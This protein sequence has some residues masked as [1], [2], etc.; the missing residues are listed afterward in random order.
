[1]GGAKFWVALPSK[2]VTSSSWLGGES[3]TAK[4]GSKVMALKIKRS[5]GAITRNRATQIKSHQ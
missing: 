3:E 4:D 5:D 1:M 2:Q